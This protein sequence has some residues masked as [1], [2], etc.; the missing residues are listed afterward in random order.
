[1]FE[2]LSFL[3]VWKMLYPTINF[4]INIYLNILDNLF[5]RLKNIFAG[6]FGAERL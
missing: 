3:S 2:V 1:M 4:N 5:V 6:K